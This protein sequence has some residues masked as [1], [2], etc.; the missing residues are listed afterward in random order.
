MRGIEEICR[1]LI[2]LG[3]RIRSTAPLVQGKTDKRELRRRDPPFGN[4]LREYKERLRSRH[5]QLPLHVRYQNWSEVT[6][7]LQAPRI[8][9]D[10]MSTE[11]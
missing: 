7:D 8:S 3:R 9:P 6:F 2:L 4:G 1:R 11:T 10:F 5:L